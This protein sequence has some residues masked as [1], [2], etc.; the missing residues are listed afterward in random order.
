MQKIIKEH[1]RPL[2]G[3]RLSHTHGQNSINMASLRF[4][5]HGWPRS[6]NTTTGERYGNGPPREQ[7]LVVT[8]TFEM[9]QRQSQPNIVLRAGLDTRIV[10]LKKP[11]NN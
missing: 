10:G 8:V 7:H 11:I 4:Q 2:S 5:K 6:R 9:H 3:T 1:D